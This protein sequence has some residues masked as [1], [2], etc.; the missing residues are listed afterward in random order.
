[1]DNGGFVL[2]D[3]SAIDKAIDM[4]DDIL[5]EYREIGEEYDRIIKA[6]LDNWKGSGAGAFE[7]DAKTVRE[8]IGGIEDILKIMIDTLIDMR[9]LYREIDTKIGENNRNIK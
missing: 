5:K 4:K 6:L 3:T 8:N 7:A 2:L 1:M 9:A